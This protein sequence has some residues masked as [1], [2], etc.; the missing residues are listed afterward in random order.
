VIPYLRALIEI[1]REQAKNRY[2]PSVGKSRKLERIEREQQILRLHR[3]G[4][5]QRQIAERLG[6]HHKT[7]ALVLKALTAKIERGEYSPLPLLHRAAIADA[8]AEKQAEIAKAVV[9][10]RFTVEETKKLVRLAR[11]KR[12]QRDNEGNK[13]THC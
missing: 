4:F 9:A 11:N 7:V 5:S 3:E 1:L 6:C 13:G 12:D 10:K 8:P 2:G